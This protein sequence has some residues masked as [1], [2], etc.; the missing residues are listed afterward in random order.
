MFFLVK[1]PVG[2]GL[3][4]GLAKRYPFLHFWHTLIKEQHKLFL[5]DLGNQQLFMLATEMCGQRQACTRMWQRTL[6]LK[7]SI[8]FW[9]H[10]VCFHSNKVTVL[11]KHRARDCVYKQH[12]PV[13][14]QKLAKESLR[15]FYKALQKRQRIQSRVKFYF[16]KT[17][18]LYV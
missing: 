3:H 4:T 6:L 9:Q 1:C 16:R 8:S 10:L 14:E 5:W 12:L 15:G 11:L 18:K 13:V 7:N 2:P 17:A